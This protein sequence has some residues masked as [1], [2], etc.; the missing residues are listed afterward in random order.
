VVTTPGTGPG[1]VPGPTAD[2]P[3]PADDRIAIVFDTIVSGDN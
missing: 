2:M 3:L 1:Q